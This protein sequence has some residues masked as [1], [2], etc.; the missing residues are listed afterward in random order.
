MAEPRDAFGLVG[1]TLAGKYRVDHVVSEAAESVIYRGLDTE[2]DEAVAIK[3]LKLV[4]GLPHQAVEPLLR[5]FQE[6]GKRRQLLSDESHGMAGVVFT[7]I[8][9]SARGDAL[10]PYLVIEWLEGGTLAALLE[11]HRNEPKPLAHVVARFDAVA[12]TLA[13]AHARGIV[14]G[15]LSPR[16]IFVATNRHAPELKVLDFRVTRSLG[17]HAAKFQK[18]ASTVAYAHDAAPSHSAPE[19]FDGRVGP[20]GPASDVYALALIVLEV[21]RGEPVNPGR[22]AVDCS[23]QALDPAHRPTPR[24]LGLEVGDEVEAV[25]VR[26]L[27]RSPEERPEDAGEFWGMLKHALAADME[28]LRP[29]PHTTAM[30]PSK[31]KTLALPFGAGP[32]TSA[33]RIHASSQVPQPKTRTVRL[34]SLALPSPAT[35][36]PMQAYDGDFAT[37][38]GPRP[39]ST[40][41]FR[42][43]WMR[44]R[45][46]RPVAVGQH[47]APLLKNRWLTAAWW[48]A[49]VLLV[50]L[51]AIAAFRLYQLRTG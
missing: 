42:G 46:Q 11:A 29:K 9:M 19:Q 16:S 5:A 2:A 33:P 36:S 39:S 25:F 30:M 4:R 21:M 43:L 31:E 27:A 47:A 14:H 44:P 3:C 18:R 51:L 24:A 6:E 45:A 32:R 13:L 35:V 8:E 26:A 20:V 17:T 34:G 28:A 50:I 7:G 37:A 12:E 48:V 38:G 10:V 22:N 49:V 1:T 23:R 41:A 15:D 40:E